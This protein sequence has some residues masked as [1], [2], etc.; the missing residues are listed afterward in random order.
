M[1]SFTIFPDAF[2]KKDG[3]DNNRITALEQ[4]AVPAT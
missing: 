1:E 2:Y 4:T 3:A